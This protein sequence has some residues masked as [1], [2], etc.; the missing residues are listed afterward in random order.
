LIQDQPVVRIIPAGKNRL[1]AAAAST[2]GGGKRRHQKAV[3][4]RIANSRP[5]LPRRF[6]SFMTACAT[7]PG[8]IGQNRIEAFGVNPAAA[9]CLGMRRF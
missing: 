1:D 8:D 2:R 6:A 4:L 3:P 7:P 9:R 5:E